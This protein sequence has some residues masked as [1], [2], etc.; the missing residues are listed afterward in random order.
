VWPLDSLLVFLII[1]SF[2]FFAITIYS[3]LKENSAVLNVNESRFFA[4]KILDTA[5][6]STLF[7]TLLGAL[8]V[9]HQF[10]LGFRPRISYKS[11]NILKQVIYNK[12]EFCEAWQV[13]IRNV[14]VGAAIINGCEF[15]FET[16]SAKSASFPL[17]FNN[18]VKEL[19]KINLINE[20]DYWLENITSGF[21]LAPNED[22]TVF[23]IKTEHMKNIKR[24]NMIL[25][26]QGFLGGKYY[27]EI[28]F[29]P[30][31]FG[32]K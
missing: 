8:V 19:A 11:M 5:T 7:V 6:S 27:K 32:N 21:T 17:G 2:I 3:I 14:G 26:F 18:V 29:M 30:R 12:T 28:I 15:E 31:A 23:E 25:H 24:L 10:V 4:L 1:L 22:Y 16:S 9:R 20:D 13:K